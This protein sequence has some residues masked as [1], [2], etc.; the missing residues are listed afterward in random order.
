M[1]SMNWTTR[2]RKSSAQIF[3]A[4]TWRRKTA[5]AA[6]EVKKS[7]AGVSTSTKSSRQW[8]SSSPATMNPAAALGF[9]LERE[10]RERRSDFKCWLVKA[11]YS[12]SENWSVRRF[13]TDK[14]LAIRIWV[15]R[16]THAFWIILSTR[17]TREMRLLWQPP[18]MDLNFF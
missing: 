7:A 13:W 18:K 12:H 10:S 11:I 6:A 17:R 16:V 1:N 5:T 15:T 14:P 2:R 4:L 3:R 8:S 9:E